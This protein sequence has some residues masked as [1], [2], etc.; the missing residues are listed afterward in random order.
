MGIAQHNKTTEDSAFRIAKSA[1]SSVVFGYLM[2]ITSDL[3]LQKCCGIMTADLKD[4]KLGQR[5]NAVAR[6]F[7]VRWFENDMM[8]FRELSIEC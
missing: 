6:C 4:R 3:A 2:N 8:R 7:G 1:E 5:I